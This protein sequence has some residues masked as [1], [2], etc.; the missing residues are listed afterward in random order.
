[1]T[2]EDLVC[3][4]YMLITTLQHLIGNLLQISNSKGSQLPYQGPTYITLLFHLQASAASQAGCGT[5][6]Q[7][8]AQ[9]L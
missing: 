8:E 3:T 9:M 4:V 7:E 5:Q 6:K 2:R 1:M